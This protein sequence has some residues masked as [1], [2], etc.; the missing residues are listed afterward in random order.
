MSFFAHTNFAVCFKQYSVQTPNR[1][2]KK[3][4]IKLWLKINFKNKFTFTFKAH[5]A[6]SNCFLIRISDD[7]QF[8]I[9]IKVTNYKNCYISAK[10][11]LTLNANIQLFY[12]IFLR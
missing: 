3:I 12:F 6:I 2:P 11:E 7:E 10:V 9:G 1:K 8:S 4:D 5:S